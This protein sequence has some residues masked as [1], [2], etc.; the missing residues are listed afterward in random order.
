[1]SRVPLDAPFEQFV[2]IT[3]K[4]DVDAEKSEP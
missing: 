3:E 4:K 2:P 1:M